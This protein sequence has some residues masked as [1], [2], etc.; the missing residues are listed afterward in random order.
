MS[1]RACG[2]ECC[3]TCS[4]PSLSCPDRDDRLVPG[5]AAAGVLVAAGA[6]HGP[7]TAIH[8]FPSAGRLPVSE[9]GQGVQLGR[10]EG[11]SGGSLLS[12]L[13]PGR[14]PECLPRHRQTLEAIVPFCRHQSH[15]HAAV[16]VRRNS[17]CGRERLGQPREKGVTWIVLAKCLLQLMDPAQIAFPAEHFRDVFEVGDRSEV[18]RIDA[19]PGAACVMDAELAEFLRE[20]T[21]SFPGHAMGETV[22]WSTANETVARTL[23]SGPNPA[24]KGILRIERAA[25]AQNLQHLR[26]VMALTTGGET[27]SLVATHA[28]VTR[29]GCTESLLLRFAIEASGATVGNGVF[30]PSARQLCASARQ[31][32]PVVFL[33]GQLQQPRFRFFAQPGVKGNSS[34][35]GGPLDT[36]LPTLI[37]N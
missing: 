36:K 37:V 14:A 8:R 4:W 19:Q 2:N 13:P 30:A 29:A 26:A 34:T 7:A 24:A 35:S 20:G 32:E 33:R 9:H 16:E 6:I 25:G 28:S 31:L 5:P 3:V 10:G 27:E 12:P 21:G 18:P 22:G 17:F 11:S 15:V 23:R 1:A